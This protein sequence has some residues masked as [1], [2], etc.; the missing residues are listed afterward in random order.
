MTGLA[1]DPAHP[2]NPPGPQQNIDSVRLGDWPVEFLADDRLGRGAFAQALAEEILAAPVSGGYVIALS[3]QWGSG[4]TSILNMTVEAL[5]QR[6]TVVQ[7]NPWL[8]SGTEA[9]VGTF[10]REIAKQLGDQRPLLK[11][12]ADKLATYGRLL[13]PVAG[14][15]GMAGVVDTVAGVAG[16]LA[17]DPS[18]FEQRAALREQLSSLDQRLLVVLDDVDRLRPDEV[19][20]IVRLVRLVGDFPN[21]LYLLAFDRRRVEEC[22]ADGDPNRGRAYLEKIVQV[23]HDV[24]VA[25]QPD[26]IGLVLDGLQSLVSE[27][28]TAALVRGDWQNIFTFVVRPLLATPRD[29]RRY[30]QSLPMTLR[31]VGDEV[32]L[33][34]LLGL[35]A[36]RILRPD[37]F[38]AIVTVGDALLSTQPTQA[39][40]LAGRDPAGGPVAPL[41]DV[42]RQ[43]AE[44]VCKWLFPAA[45]RYFENMNFGPEWLTTWRKDRRVASPAVFRFYLERRLPDGVVPARTIDELL[46][47]LRDPGR[48]TNLLADLSAAE[49]LDAISRLTTVAEDIEFDATRSLDDDPARI[50]LPILLDLLPRLPNSPASPRD[51]GATMTIARLAH[52]LIKRIDREE[53]RAAV[54]RAVFADTTVLS[55]RLAL[56]FVLG[57]RTNIGTGLIGVD[58]AEDMEGALREALISAAPDLLATEPNPVGLAELMVE[59]EP[60]RDALTLAAE[61]DS[62]MLGLVM[63]S[64]GEA[65]SQAHGAAAVE[66]TEVL[67]WDRLVAYLGEDLLV[68]RIVDLMEAVLARSLAADPEQV[69]ALELASRYAVGW[70]PDTA[71]DRIMNRRSGT[72]PSNDPTVGTPDAE[73]P[74]TQNANAAAAIPSATSDVAQ[75]QSDGHAE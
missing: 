3:G 62:F 52:R 5:D 61:D 12:I 69:Q 17:S 66:I 30:L 46:S 15:F 18:V 35:E 70:R 73:T 24:P 16:Q 42:D 63:G 20:D 74:P 41:V 39:G 67:G 23:T 58:D 33:A 64:R 49:L 38:E 65:H 11:S 4:K 27:Y 72:E 37:M 44:T 57:H 48:L 60:G 59:T 21:T 56:L 9:L 32:A 71:M 47:S 68:R 2:Q 43:L 34:D 53:Q 54:V 10:F 6:A 25:R 45:R 1:T 28:P 29:A 13:S 22:L 31:L 50:A 7:F 36:I 8:F 26:V 14:V 40:Y 55:A 51:F 75:N 19:Q